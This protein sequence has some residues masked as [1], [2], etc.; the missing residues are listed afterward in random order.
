MTTSREAFS[1]ALNAGENACVYEEHWETLTV[2][3]RCKIIALTVEE[4]VRKIKEIAQA[5]H[6]SG[7]RGQEHECAYHEMFIWAGGALA[8]IF[9]DE[10]LI[11]QLSP[12][13]AQYLTPA[14]LV[15]KGLKSMPSQLWPRGARSK[16]LPT[17][18]GLL[19][20]L[21]KDK[22]T[23]T[24]SITERWRALNITI[25]YLMART[26]MDY[27]HAR[28]RTQQAQ[29]ED[30]AAQRRQKRQNQQRRRNGK[31]LSPTVCATGPVSTPMSTLLD[32]SSSSESEYVFTEYRS[33]LHF[34][35]RPDRCRTR[36]LRARSL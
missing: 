25:F 23:R 20:K 5:L 36:R 10:A 4:E 6:E 35:R 27:A 8:H 18:M 16:T 29:L 2:L 13:V 26:W 15:Q 32:M 19:T 3:Q 9:P 22:W 28:E 17:S 33:F 11:L 31:R 21:A 1:A 7:E 34:R 12:H 24:L 30:K 14:L